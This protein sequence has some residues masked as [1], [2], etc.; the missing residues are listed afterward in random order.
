[1]GMADYFLQGFGSILPDGHPARAELM[2]APRLG[3]EKHTGLVAYEMTE[4]AVDW[5][6][7][8]VGKEGGDK[9]VLDNLPAPN[10]DLEGRRRRIFQVRAT[11][12]LSREASDHA[13]K[14][15]ELFW[16]G[17]L[18]PEAERAGACFYVLLVGRES[19]DDALAT[20]ATRQAA[21]L[22][23]LGNRHDPEDLHEWAEQ[24]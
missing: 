9:K 15:Q 6:Q 11:G 2:Q 16:E 5:L 20:E 13:L 14:V 8:L 23:D 3:N 17:R 1:M 4:L 19:I 18:F 21:Q 7:E 22:N 24:S 12:P 10:V